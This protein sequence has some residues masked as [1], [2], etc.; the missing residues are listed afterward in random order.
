VGP[1]F[2]VPSAPQVG[3][4]TKEPL[5][6]RT[7]SATVSRNGQAQHFVNGRCIPAEWWALYR[8]PGL[9]SLIRRAIDTNPNLHSTMAA[10]RAAKENV[11]SQQG[12]YFPLV[13]ANF[14]PTRQQTS[15]PI[16]SAL[17]N[18]ASIYSLITGQLLVSYT[19]DAFGLNRRTVESL[20]ATADV[21][22]FQVEAAYLTLTSY[23]YVNHTDTACDTPCVGIFLGGNGTPIH[24]GANETQV[25]IGL[26]YRL[27]GR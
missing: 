8:S 9:N 3:R 13:E 5:A 22:R 6:S 19:F 20:Q 25:R 21:Q 2:L 26:N 7:E 14:N 10:L 23:L 24:I 27:W 1:D 12:K 15:A 17:N 16:S 11:Y 18:G 4:Y